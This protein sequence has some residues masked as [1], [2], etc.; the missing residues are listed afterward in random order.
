MTLKNRKESRREIF[1]S[2]L[3]IIEVGFSWIF[4][5]IAG[6]VILGLFI[7]ISSDQASFFRDLIN[8]NLLKDLNAI[9][10][11]AT[12]S[13]DTAALFEIPKTELVFDCDSY[14][15]GGVTHPLTGHIVYA[16]PLL[17][18]NELITWTKPW[19]LGFRV[20]NFLY[21]T[22]PFIKYYVIYDSSHASLAAEVYDDLPDQLTKEM[23]AI[24]NADGSYIKNQGYDR[25]HVLVLAGSTYRSSNL[26]SSLYNPNDFKGYGNDEIKFIMLYDE[27]KIADTILKGEI[28]IKNK[29]QEQ[30]DFNEDFGGEPRLSQRFYDFSSLYAAFISGNHNVWQ[31]MTDK[32][33]SR[34]RDVASIYKSR[35]QS[36]NSN[37]LF[38]VCNGLYTSADNQ[39]TIMKQNLGDS[40]VIIKINEIESDIILFHNINNNLERASCPLLY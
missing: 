26:P 19:S 36:L 10:V 38:P 33:Y 32:S 11:G 8:A 14:G 13:K 17:K 5:L 40:G 34:A 21:I 27:T 18:T 4:I 28:V 29:K 9:F 30:Q 37:I 39:F 25:I 31:C 22:S 6:V 16:P 24:G 7:Y 23:I 2:K 15:I 3:G 1:H 35:T 20:T 12:V